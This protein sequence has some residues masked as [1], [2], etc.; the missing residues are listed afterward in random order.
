M[1]RQADLTEA[2]STRRWPHPHRRSEWASLSM[3]A[4]LERPSADG[5][6]DAD[7]GSSSEVLVLPDRQNHARSGTDHGETSLCGE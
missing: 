7:A 6:T 3:S 5:V 2:S 1:S 4:S